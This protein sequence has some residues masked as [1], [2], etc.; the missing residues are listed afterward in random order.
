MNKKLF[1]TMEMARDNLKGQLDPESQRFIDRTILERKLDGEPKTVVATKKLKLQDIILIFTGLHLDDETRQKVKN[2]K[3]KISDLQVEFNKN[4]T[5]ESTK[6][7]FTGEQLREYI[8]YL[9][10]HVFK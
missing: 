9:L 4:C 5:E 10:F 3:E 7:F 1:D 2:L 6:L 8:F